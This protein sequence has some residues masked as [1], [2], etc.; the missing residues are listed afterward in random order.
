[1]NRVIEH[2]QKLVDYIEENL[3]EPIDITT[4]AHN[5]GIS[6]WYLQHSF[7]AL[8]GDT[9]GAYVRGRKMSEAI[10]M[11]ANT[12]MTLLDIAVRLGFSSHEAFTRAFQKQYDMTPS[13]YRKTR[14][15]VLHAAKPTLSDELLQHLRRDLDT[16]PRIYQRDT[17]RFVG[18][19]TEL[20]SPFIEFDRSC[21]DMNPAWM[22]LFEVQGRIAHRIEG[23]YVGAIIS[24]S[25]K[26]TEEF[27][28]HVAAIV[29]SAQGQYDEVQRYVEFPPQLVAEFSIARIDSTTVSRTIDYIYGFWLPNSPYTRA[30]GNDY[31]FFEGVQTFSADTG[32]KYILPIR[33][34]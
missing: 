6:P 20:P 13:S 14:P 1:M 30:D 5:F 10:D 22:K 9:L 34:I 23:S 31:E 27:V 17:L 32:S 3:D 11:L 16:T 2:T 7:R 24:P 33:E 12:D 21:A 28:D 19:T 8:V 15:K 26:F 25:G 29:V 18:Y 4:I